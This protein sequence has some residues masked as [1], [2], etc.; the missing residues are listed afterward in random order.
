[1]RLAALRRGGAGACLA[2][3]ALAT[4]W[5]RTEPVVEANGETLIG[6]WEGDRSD[7]ATFKGVPFAAPPMGE[8]RWRAPQPHVARA[9]RQPAQAFA[10]ACMQGPHITNWYAGVAAEFGHGPDSVGKPNGVSEDCLYLNLWTPDPS[11]GAKLP[12]MVWSHGG[13]NKGGWSYE[14]NY[15]GERLAA[16]GVVVVSFAYRLGPFGFF[17]HP[18]LDN[19][20]GQPVANFGLLDALRAFEWVKRHIEA[21]G[22]DPDNITAFGES[23]GGGNIGNW[24]V[25]EIAEQALYRRVIVQSSG[26]AAG[27]LR[28]LAEEQALGRRLI[29]YLGFGGE[30]PSAAQLR[31]IPAEDLVRATYEALP[32]HY[33]DVVRDGLTFAAQPLDN[34][35]SAKIAEVDILIGTNAHEWYMY[36]DESAGWEEVETWLQTNAPA[37]A[38]VLR[39][40]VAGEADPRRAL[41][42]LRTAQRMLCPSHYVAGRVSAAGGRA[43]VYYFNRQRPGPGGRKLG[44]YHGTEIGYVFNQ[45]E[46]WQSVDEA[47]LRLTQAVMDYWVQFARSGD[48]NVLGRPEWPRYRA[49]RPLVMELGDHL[50]AIEP[51]DADLCLWLGPRR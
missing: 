39:S 28:T 27:E 41:D 40:L 13:S 17:A 47:D 34:Y 37:S 44:V 50:G 10:P 15:H 16:K 45:H 3:F 6:S 23:S 4:A 51:P 33:F 29:S 43:W 49:G 19:G 48:P 22:G 8:L 35:D 21:F 1:M 25:S 46:P 11:P 38:T 24:L 31:A 12:V 42:R 36:V 30:G 14:P 18:A 26:S 32:G 2:A 9:G 5:A 7:I 20:P